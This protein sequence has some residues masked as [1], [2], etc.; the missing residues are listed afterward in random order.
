MN[1]DSADEITKQNDNV[2]LI[3]LNVAVT[4]W[5]RSTQLFYIEPG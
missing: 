2:G 4:H 1:F 3:R 5:S